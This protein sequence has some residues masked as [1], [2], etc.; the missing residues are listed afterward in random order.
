MQNQSTSTARTNAR[1][2]RREMTD[3]ERKLW[4]ALRSEQ[5]GVKFRRQHPLGN[6]IADF[7]CLGPKLI[8]E[9]D[10][11]QHQDQQAYDA[12][13]DAFFRAQGF[14]VL[15]FPTNTPFLNLDGVLQVIADRLAA[16]AVPAPIPAFPQRGKEQNYP[17]AS[18]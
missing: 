18:S 6:Y 11:S 15:R 7:A 16:L 12:M 4:I 2:L 8:V 5:L 10:G 3:S 14:E 1:T 17:G 9:L 13:R